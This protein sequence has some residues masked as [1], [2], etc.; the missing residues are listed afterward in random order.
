MASYWW[1]MKDFVSKEKEK[2]GNMAQLVRT[3]RAMTGVH[4]QDGE[5]EDQLPQVVL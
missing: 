4:P 2:V 1:L 5:R 3:V